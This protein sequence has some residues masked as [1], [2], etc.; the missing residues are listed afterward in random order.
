VSNCSLPEA[1]LTVDV[2]SDDRELLARIAHRWYLDDRTQTQI[3]QEFG[4]SRPKVQRLLVRARQTGVVQ[5]HIDAPHGVDLDLEARLIAA[6]GL[7]DAI[8]SPSAPDPEIRRAAVARAAAGYLERRL[9]DGMVVAVSHGRDIGAIPRH[10]RPAAPVD[11]AFASAMG[12][13]PTIDLPTNPNEIC[14]A[15]AERSG[16]RAESLFAP[17]Y[18][19]SAEVRDSLHAQEAVSHVLRMAAAADL[20]L[21][22]IGGTDDH[23]TMVRSGSLD[24]AEIGRLRDHGAVG[25]VLGN[26]VDTRGQ[27]IASPHSSRLIG[28]SVDDL[29]RI[30]HVVAVVS[31]AEKPRATLGVLRA[32][33]VDVLIV[34]EANARTVLDLATGGV[35]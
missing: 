23:C 1:G 16:G 25:D 29:R 9:V 22:G 8:V 6:F 34:D 31:G 12:G 21:V 24:V 26:Y 35:A 14:R 27:L 33:I 5:I 3:A 20:A 10:F 4:L 11:C 28:L 13:S 18:V 30:P 7:A 2:S 32:G 15:L 17:A 19:E